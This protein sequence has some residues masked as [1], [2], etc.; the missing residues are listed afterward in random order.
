MDYIEIEKKPLVI[1]NYFNPDKKESMDDIIV[2]VG[3]NA[4]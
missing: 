3:T 4:K 2:S 1:K